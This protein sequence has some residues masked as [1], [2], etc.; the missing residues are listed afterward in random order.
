MKTKKFQFVAEYLRW[1]DA[2]LAYHNTFDTTLTGEEL[3]PIA[4]A[5]LADP[6]VAAAIQAAEAGIRSRAEQ[7]QVAE[8]E[9]PVLTVKHKR[10]ILYQIATGQ[11]SAEQSYKGKDCNVCSQ[12]VR[13]T[14]N[15]MLRAIQIDNQLAGHKTTLKS[16][17]PVQPQAEKTQQK[18]PR[19]SLQGD[20]TK[21]SNQ[22]SRHAELDSVSGATQTTRKDQTLPGHRQEKQHRNSTTIHNKKFNPPVAQP[23]RYQFSRKTLNF[24]VE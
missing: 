14:I 12:Y 5:Y 7:G 1:G 22:L 15:H 3:A 20:S 9:A 8:Q 19:Q 4:E 11:L 10:Q 17:N 6:E 24:P 23:R 13:P 2:M 21:Q 18:H 16:H